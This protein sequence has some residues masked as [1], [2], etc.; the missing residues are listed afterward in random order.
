MGIEDRR[1]VIT[2]AARDFGR[3]LAV[4]LADLGA[5]LY[6]SSR[7]PAG[8][9]RTRDEIRARGHD[10]V[11]AFACDLSVPESI[12]DF[13][14]GVRERTD[15]VDVVV[16]NGAGWLEGADI[17]SASDEDIVST[18]TSGGAGT[19][20]MVK[21]F[22]PLL[23]ASPQPDIVTMVSTAALPNVDG[24]RGHGAFYAAK[25]AQAA[26]TGIMSR[27]LRAAGI[28]VIS[29]YPPDFHNVDPLAEPGSV[30]REAKDMLTAESL[31]E[32]IV[33]AISQPR[34]CF[35]NSFVFE[36]S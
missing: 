10:R 6:L 13:A 8:A 30:S 35:I 12:R 14:A 17:E 29:L 16:N 7:D 2:G 22:M 28:R 15:R 31:V 1:I 4:R 34:D 24:C 25:G 3:T 9:R 5:E 23:S 21:H 33:F 32:C 27:R 20:L 26:F 19:V 18:I 11:H 36:S